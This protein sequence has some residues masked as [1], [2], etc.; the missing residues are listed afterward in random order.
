MWINFVSQLVTEGTVVYLQRM[1]K[2]PYTDEFLVG[3]IVT[4]MDQLRKIVQRLENQEH[5]TMRELEHVRDEIIEINNDVEVQ[6]RNVTDD[7]V[8]PSMN[9]FRALVRRAIQTRERREQRLRTGGP[10]GDQS[11]AGIQFGTIDPEQVDVLEIETGDT[12]AAYASDNEDPLPLELMSTVRPSKEFEPVVFRPPTPDLRDRLNRHRAQASYGVRQAERDRN[13]PVRNEPVRS[14]EIRREP[15]SPMPVR[16]DRGRGRGGMQSRNDG[17]SRM[18]ERSRSDARG[19]AVASTSTVSHREYVPMPQERLSGPVSGRPYPPLGRA[20]PKPLV[21]R[22]PTLIGLSEIYT[23]PPQA[24]PKIC[25]ICPGGKHKLY[26]CLTFQRMGLQE[27]WYTAL[28]KGVCLHCLIRGHSHFT[29]RSEGTCHRC[30]K[31]HN[32]MLCPDGPS[33]RDGRV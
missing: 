15:E 1:P 20:P 7:R 30:G 22:D 12:L 14:E 10:H 6:S 16:R 5:F 17:P 29:C 19:R 4:R 8:T 13:E 24:D 32:S 2:L 33:N 9:S 28:K 27:R 23:H 3:V 25:P 26:G 18:T 21:R 31:R 11:L